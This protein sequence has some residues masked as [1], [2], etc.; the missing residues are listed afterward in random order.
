MSNTKE[1]SEKL[2]YKKKTVYERAA[3]EALDAA[4]DYARG[5]AAF[6]DSGLR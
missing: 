4:F 1:G 3:K 2:F 6:L 5:Y